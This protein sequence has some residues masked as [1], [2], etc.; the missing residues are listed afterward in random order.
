MPH[1][2]VGTPNQNFTGYCSFREKELEKEIKISLGSGYV[3]DLLNLHKAMKV[4]DKQT[5]LNTQKSKKCLPAM[6]NTKAIKSYN[7]KSV[8]ILIDYI[9]YIVL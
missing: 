3:A 1:E 6:N 2:A 5:S 7:L 8:K 9:E 4:I